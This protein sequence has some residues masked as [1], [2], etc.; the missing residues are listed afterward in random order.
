[1]VSAVAVSRGL[2]DSEVERTMT[3]DQIELHF[4]FLQREQLRTLFGYRA[5]MKAAAVEAISM[6]FG[7]Q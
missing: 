6:A 5:A 7:G 3:M 2:S 1:M 4:H